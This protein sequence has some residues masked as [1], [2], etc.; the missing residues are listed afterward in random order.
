MMKWDIDVSSVQLCKRLC[1][2]IHD[3]C[4]HDRDHS[5]TLLAAV[6]SSCTRMHYDCTP[7]PNCLAI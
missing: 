6:C 4:K 7:S 2:S 3:G 1:C 5:E